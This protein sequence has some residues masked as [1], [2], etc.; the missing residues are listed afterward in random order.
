VAIC[1]SYT[2]AGQE[3]NIS[4][5]SLSRQ[6]SALEDQLER[7]LFIR[8][9]KGVDFTEAG[10]SLFDFA[11]KV[12]FDMQAYKAKFNDDTQEIKGSVKISTTH[13][14]ADYIL[15]KVLSKFKHKHPKLTLDIVCSDNLI[16]LV[17]NEVDV[18]IRPSDDENQNIIQEHLFTLHAGIYA[19][20]DYL[21]KYGTPK[22]ASDLD[23]HR[24][25]VRSHSEN[26]PYS[27][28]AWILKVGKT[29]GK[30]EPYFISNS[31]EILFKAAEEGNG[32]I[33]SYEP[34]V[35]GSKRKLVRVLPDLKGPGYKDFII[36]P[37]S[38]ADI[39]KIK[40]IK[41]FLLEEFQY[42]RSSV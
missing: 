41:D 34:M 39:N 27:D 37:K 40:L 5:S 4:Q 13:A 17:A 14:I 1:K 24:L 35:K 29:K 3:L 8:R 25:L 42:L 23:N 15:Y 6:V 30:R 26:Y 9:S 38:L 7:K 33:T 19:S 28:V 22:T 20:K 32:L 31:S 12:F 21:D 11:Q 2:R 18:A 10:K 16:D 36:Y